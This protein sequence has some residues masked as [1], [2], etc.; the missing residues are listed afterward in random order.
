MPFFF[1]FSFLPLAPAAGSKGSLSYVVPALLGLLYVYW[2]HLN[3]FQT[4][5]Y[6]AI[7]GGVTFLAGNRMLAQKAVKR[8]VSPRC[9]N[10]WFLE[11]P[12]SRRPLP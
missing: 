5:K 9:R 10:K 1:P 2:T 3:M 7:V 4:L 8:Y 6:L 11:S 12:Q